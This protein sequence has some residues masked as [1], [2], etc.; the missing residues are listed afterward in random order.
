MDLEQS[1]EQFK[2]PDT[3]PLAIKLHEHEKKKEFNTNSMIAEENF[4]ARQKL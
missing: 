1:H 2:S 3:E 4:E